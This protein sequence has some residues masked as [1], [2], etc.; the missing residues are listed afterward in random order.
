[1]KR[2]KFIW[3]ALT[4]L[5]CALHFI[6]FYILVTTALK[7]AK[8]ASSKWVFPSYLYLDNFAAVWKEANFGYAFANNLIIFVVSVTVIVIIGS[9][10]SYPLARYKTR[11]NKIVYSFFVVMI[12]VPPLAILVPLY[13][14][15]VQMGALNTYWGIICLHVAFNLP[16]AIFFLTGFIGLIPRELDEAAMIDGSS[17]IGMFF[18]II[19]PLLKPATVTVII[20]TGIHIWNDYQFSIFFMQK[21]RYHTITVALAKFFGQNNNNINWVAAGALIGAS[22]IIIVFLFLQRFFIDGLASGSVKG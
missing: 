8:D 3:N 14:L 6:P 12:I 18:K 1:M 19:M 5:I 22:P 4:L 10:S 7:T 17:R 13:N 15:Y 11:I 16:L 21:I 9:I 20:L 2:S